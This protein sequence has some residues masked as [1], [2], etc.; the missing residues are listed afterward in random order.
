[1]F[2]CAGLQ[3]AVVL[4]ATA[5]SHTYSH[6]GKVLDLRGFQGIAQT[7]ERKNSISQSSTDVV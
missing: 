7:A 2:V 6:E 4:T 3:A 1:M 5:P